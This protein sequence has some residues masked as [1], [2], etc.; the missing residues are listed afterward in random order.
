MAYLARTKKLT[1][2]R[3]MISTQGFCLRIRCCCLLSGCCRWPPKPLGLKVWFEASSDREMQ[4]LRPHPSPLESETMSDSSP[5][6]HSRSSTLSLFFHVAWKSTEG[7]PVREPQ[8][9]HLQEALALGAQ[10]QTH[11]FLPGTPESSISWQLQS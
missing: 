3:V 8:D 9:S 7:S 2:G 4:S 10:A 1:H 11:P 6:E 5:H